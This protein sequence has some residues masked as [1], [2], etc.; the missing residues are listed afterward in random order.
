MLPLFILPDEQEQYRIM[1][2]LISNM[3]KV[4]NYVLSADNQYNY[5]CIPTEITTVHPLCGVV[6]FPP[7]STRCS[8]DLSYPVR[9]A[10]SHQN[11]G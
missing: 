7:I 11:S 3:V 4:N 10:T 2:L 1:L 8:V 9:F 6:P 5:N